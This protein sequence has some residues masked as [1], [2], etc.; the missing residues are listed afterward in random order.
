VHSF[1]QNVNEEMRA[2]AHVWELVK[3]F[4]EKNKDKETLENWGIGNTYTN[5]WSSPTYMVSVEDQKLRGGGRALKQ[6]IWTSARD[7]IQE[8]TGEEVTECS[9]YGIRV[10]KEN[11]VL[12]THVD[13]LPLVSSIIINV[14]QDCE[15]CDCVSMEIW[16]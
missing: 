15:Y 7:S 1:L 2:P 13:R 8:W 9:L 3:D 12:S 10:Y 16:K 11:A 6:A 14:A 4:W 5:N